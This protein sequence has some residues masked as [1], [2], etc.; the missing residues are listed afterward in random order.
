MRSCF[1]CQQEISTHKA[2]YCGNCGFPILD[3]PSE[4]NVRE[5]ARDGLSGF[6]D[7]YDVESILN[8]M[9][10]E[11]APPAEP[12]QWYLEE[13]V[14]RGLTDLVILQQWEWFD[15][16]PVLGLFLHKEIVE[17]DPSDEAMENFFLWARISAFLY[18]MLQPAGIEFSIRVGAALA[19]GVNPTEDI[20]VSITVG[21]DDEE[22]ESSFGP[23]S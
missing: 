17:D 4:E 2:N 14:K 1:R 19:E 23:A 22:E 20:D 11:Q 8:S 18:E 16:E 15:K 9:N 7:G 3:D 21:S 12:Y 10:G 6:L 13:V 5:S